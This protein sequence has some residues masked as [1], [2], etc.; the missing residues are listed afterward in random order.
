MY[1]AEKSLCLPGCSSSRTYHRALPNLRPS[2]LGHPALQAG[3]CSGGFCTPDEQPAALE[4]AI[5]AA[6]EGAAVGTIVEGVA[7]EETPESAEPEEY[8]EEEYHPTANEWKMNMELTVGMI[9]G[10]IREAVL[11]DAFAGQFMGSEASLITPDPVALSD[12]HP[13]PPI[14]LAVP[15]QLAAAV[16]PSGPTNTTPATNGTAPPLPL[17]EECALN[18]PGSSASSSYRQQAAEA[19]AT[20][21][22]FTSEAGRLADM[23]ADMVAVTA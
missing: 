14:E 11:G 4:A 1:A 18:P 6:Q 20:R 13:A 19:S 7:A 8:E 3:A 15:D 12:T 2:S 9:N 10:V 16:L 22:F 23:V 21:D 5:E 17:A